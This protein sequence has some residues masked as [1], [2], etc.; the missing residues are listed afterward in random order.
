[1]RKSEQK[2]QTK[3]CP[4]ESKIKNTK[5]INI[6]ICLKKTNKN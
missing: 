1:M 6:K 3:I 2:I 5:K 4:K